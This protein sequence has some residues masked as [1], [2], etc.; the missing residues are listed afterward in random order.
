MLMPSCWDTFEATSAIFFLG[1]STLGG[2]REYELPD[3]EPPCKV[4]E[5]R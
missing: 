4:E 2:D 5:I 1:D 3:W